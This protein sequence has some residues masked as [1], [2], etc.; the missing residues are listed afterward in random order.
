MNRTSLYFSDTNE[1]AV[2]TERIDAPGDRQV[3][4]KSLIS[5]ISSGTEMLI[6]HGNVPQDMAIDTT[7][8]DLTGNFVYPFKYGY[9][10]VGRIIE[11]GSE[12]DRSYL[13]R[14][15]FAFHPHESHF[16][17][18]AD[19]LIPLPHD[20]SPEDAVFLP[21]METAINLLFDGKP[22]L[23]EKVVVFGQG[24]VG[25][26]TTSLLRN[27]PLCTLITLDQYELRRKLS[28]SLGA[29][30][31][32]NPFKK[33]F[34]ADITAILS[35]SEYYKAADLCFE[36]SGN[37]YALDQAI[38]LTGLDGRIIIGSWYGKKRV[39]INLGDT[40]HRN[41]IRLISS[42]V[43]NVSP[44][45]SGRWTKK[46]RFDM[47]MR[48]IKKVKPNKFITHKFDINKADAA[49]ELLNKYP[50]NAIQVILTY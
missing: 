26:L 35:E 6:Y 15:V 30:Y 4:V 40:F 3:L 36:L 17:A 43:S 1:I 19:D 24:I 45:M 49:Y 48:M 32:L 10:L 8:K 34:H 47:A 11:I 12:I 42:Q 25:L 16:I 41:R 13:D 29:D 46:R 44:E 37:P 2:K 18:D 31:S 14:L 20:L 38:H 5:A 33:G 7:L 23:G 28:L 39:D 22:L 21:N 50:E 9:S 27:F